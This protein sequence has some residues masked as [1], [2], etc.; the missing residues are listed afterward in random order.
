MKRFSFRLEPVLKQREMKEENA[1]LAFS[2]A[3]QE[4]LHSM[5]LLNDIAATLERTTGESLDNPDA[6]EIINKALYIDYLNKRLLQC[7]TAVTK[8]GRV[9][10]E[11]RAM[12]IDARKDRMVIDRLKQNQFTAYIDNLNNMEQKALDEMGTVQYSRKRG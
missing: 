7:E 4:Y 1:I 12:M 10:E 2:S 8:A 5:Q 9:L 3:Q 11:K 6:C